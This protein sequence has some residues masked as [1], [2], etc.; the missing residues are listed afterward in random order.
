MGQSWTHPSQTHA[1]RFPQYR[2]FEI[3]FCLQLIESHERW[4]QFFAQMPLQWWRLLEPAATTTAFCPKALLLTSSNPGKERVI[5]MA[6]GSP[7]TVLRFGR[8]RDH[9]NK[10]FQ[11]SIDCA[12]CC[13]FA[14]LKQTPSCRFAIYVHCCLNENFKVSGPGQC[15]FQHWPLCDRKCTGLWSLSVQFLRLKTRT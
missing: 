9:C 10:W 7:K 11:V 8:N 3:C 14:R 15:T 1:S 13:R 5:A 12:L 2:V 6:F 4:D